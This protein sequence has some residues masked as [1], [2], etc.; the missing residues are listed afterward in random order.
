MTA[1]HGPCAAVRPDEWVLRLPAGRRRRRR[2]APDRLQDPPRDRRASSGHAGDR[3]AVRVR[4]AVRRDKQGVGERRARLRAHLARL[5]LETHP[6][7]STPPTRHY[8]IHGILCVQSEGKLPELEPFRVDALDRPPDVLVRIG[9]LPTEAPKAPDRFSRHLRYRERTGNLGFAADVTI[10]ERVEVLA[11]PLLRRSPHVLY[12]NLVEPILR[13]EFAR[14][15]Y[16]L[17]H[18][19][20]VSRGDDAFMI[21]ARTDTGKTTTMLKLLD[22]EPYAFISDDLTIV[23]PNGDLL[24]YPKPLTIS[25]HTLHAVKRPLS[26]A[27][28]AHD[29]AAAEPPAL[30]IGSAVRIPPRQD[31][32]ARGH[33][34]HGRAAVGAPAEVPRAAV[35]AGV[36]GRGGCEARRVVGHPERSVTASSGSKSRT[37]SRS[38][39]RIARMRMDS[40]RI[41]TS[42]TFCSRGP[43]TTYAASSAQCSRRRSRAVR[44]RSVQHAP[45][46]GRA[47]PSTDRGAHDRRR[48][49][50]RGDGPRVD[51]DA[52]RRGRRATG[53]PVTG[54]GTA[55]PAPIPAAT[56]E[57]ATRWSWERLKRFRASAWSAPRASW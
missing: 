15:G 19:A 2:A 12:T 10:G 49:R 40:R 41:T 25:N 56:T 39:S 50:S 34:E 51:P 5:R 1:S 30:S 26:A 48:C 16:A 44:P 32:D 38:C 45:G 29:A 17:A 33:R 36:R 28:G 54:G 7:A 53:R 13:W 52:R 35:G 20:C 22:A 9:P 6:G 47:D 57:A 4:R 31:G 23:G 37:R 14:R 3:G 8:D 46:L 43:S 24:P 42:R 55:S 11:A 27:V 21:T 18:G